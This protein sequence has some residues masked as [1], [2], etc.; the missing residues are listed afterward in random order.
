MGEFAIFFGRKMTIDNLIPLQIT[1]FN[2]K[3]F[4]LDVSNLTL[5]IF[6]IDWMLERYPLFG[7][8]SRVANPVKVPSYLFY[9][10]IERSLRQCSFLNHP[11]PEQIAWVWTSWQRW[12]LRKYAKPSPLY[13]VS[14]SLIN[15]SNFFCVDIPIFGLKRLLR[16]LSILYLTQPIKYWLP[17]RYTVRSGLR[18]K[19]FR[20]IRRIRPLCNYGIVTKPTIM[21]CSWSATSNLLKRN[22]SITK[23]LRGYAVTSRCT[24]SYKALS[25]LSYP[26]PLSAKLCFKHRSIEVAG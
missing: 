19:G 9:T 3:D 2:K 8:E 18:S 4:K 12:C 6:I 21:L 17:P 25:F 5:I 11:N 16:G 7:L 24:E 13:N 22:Q 26:M 10:L 1:C 15:Y 14:L 23:S 20:S